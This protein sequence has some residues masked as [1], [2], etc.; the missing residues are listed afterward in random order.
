LLALKIDKHVLFGTDYMQ[1]GLAPLI[2]PP[3][4]IQNRYAK[5]A[6]SNDLTIFRLP[7]L[8]LSF[9]FSRG[10][11]VGLFLSSPSVFSGVRVTGSLV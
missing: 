4:L 9:F 5:L 10:T 1:T 11:I 6:H 2:L 3:I 7:N 8:Y